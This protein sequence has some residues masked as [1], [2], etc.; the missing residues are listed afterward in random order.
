MHFGRNASQLRCGTDSVDFCHPEGPAQPAIRFSET[1]DRGIHE[2]TEKRGFSSPKVFIRHA[3]E[4]ELSGHADQLVT[5]EQRLGEI[6]YFS[7]RAGQA[8]PGFGPNGSDVGTGDVRQAVIIAVSPPDSLCDQ[9][10]LPL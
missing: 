10:S 3:V 5:T 8:K 9:N 6:G 2:A 7:M 1:T 4:R